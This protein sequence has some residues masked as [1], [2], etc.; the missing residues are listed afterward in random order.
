MI[1]VTEGDKK[2]NNPVA[3]PPGELKVVNSPIQSEMATN[4]S[5]Y[6]PGSIWASKFRSFDNA[7]F[8]FQAVWV[9]KTD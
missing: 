2:N 9:T 8:N 1:L 6:R 4:Q 7:D 3:E 5:G